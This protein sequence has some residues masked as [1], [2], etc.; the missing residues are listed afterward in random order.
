MKKVLIAIDD[1][2]GSE[3][4]DSTFIDLFSSDRSVTALLVYIQKIE[5]RS[6]MDDML[7]EAELSTLKE[8]LKGTEYKKLLDKKAEKVISYHREIL[9]KSGVTEIKTLIRDG[10][11]A[12]EILNTAKEEGADMIIIGSRGTRM[13]NL[14]M[15]SVS[16]EV[17]GRADIPVLL[18][19]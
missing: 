15:G 5:G 8:M 16:R 17:A 4:A 3:A 2:K 19:K 18:A 9:K 14:L 13:H 10:H 1:S 11:P 12:D 6:F 7:G